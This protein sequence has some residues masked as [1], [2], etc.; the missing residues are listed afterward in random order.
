M[1]PIEDK[2]ERIRT[3]NYVVPILMRRAIRAR[4]AMKEARTGAEFN[5]A[6]RYAREADDLVVKYRN[7]LFDL[8]E[9]R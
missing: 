6:V 9:A 8:T 7:E 1:L 5:E 2:V 3:L 4:R